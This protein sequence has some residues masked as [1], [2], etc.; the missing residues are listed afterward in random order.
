M[1]LG[2][3]MNMS[4]IATVAAVLPQI[5]AA[6]GLS[7]SEAGWIGG[8]YFGGYAA[9]VPILAT[10]IDRIDGRWVFAGSSLLAAGAS[11]AFA[12]CADGFWMA[13]VLCLVGGIALA[14]VHMPGLKLLN[15]RSDAAGR[16]AARSILR[17]IRSA[18]RFLF[19]L[20]APSI[21]PSAGAQ[22]SRSPASCRLR[23]S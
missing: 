15:A 20:P 17:F 23:R 8:I 9:V 5:A 4:L 3:L 12:G 2:L 7:A 10:L 19:L 21:R 14:G 6:W 22:P 16:V 13:L 18:P 11:L 1:S